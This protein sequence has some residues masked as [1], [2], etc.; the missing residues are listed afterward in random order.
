MQ[1]S[2]QIQKQQNL[3]LQN[4]RN[5]S[6]CKFFKTNSCKYQHARSDQQNVPGMR[7]QQYR[8]DQQSSK[9]QS[10]F[11]HSTFNGKSPAFQGQQNQFQQRPQTGNQRSQNQ[12]QQS[13]MSG[14]SRQ[15]MSNNQPQITVDITDSD[16]LQAIQIKT[17]FYCESEFGVQISVKQLQNNSF[18]QQEQ[19]FGTMSITN[20][21]GGFQWYY[22]V[23]KHDANYASRQDQINDWFELDNDQNVQV[24]S[25]YQ[26]CCNKN[27]FGSEY[28]IVGDQNRI[29]NG[30]GYAVFGNSQDPS[31]WYEK[32]MQIGTQ[33]QL[34]R[35]VTP[36]TQ[37]VSQVMTPYQSNQNQSQTQ[38]YQVT[39][40][41]SQIQ[42]FNT[43]LKQFYKNQN[44]F[45][46]S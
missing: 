30:F 28:Y 37:T 15:Q 7:T 24:E 41:Q 20:N 4:C 8:F 18:Q 25:H 44:V 12:S 34:Q 6:A 11:Q 26:D 19:Q 14:M 33:R 16:V 13:N 36:Q 39:G 9:A 17:I 40:T 45:G 21:S 31:T 38:I 3:S 27:S 5:G 22:K 32:N 43:Q 10:H 42:Y 35:R 29:K 23:Y 1:R 46:N 2:N